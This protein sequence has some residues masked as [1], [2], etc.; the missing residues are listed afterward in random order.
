MKPLF[1]N[2]RSTSQSSR[3]NTIKLRRHTDLRAASI[4]IWLI[5]GITACFA[6][7]PATKA[8]P[9]I[10]AAP[11]PVIYVVKPKFPS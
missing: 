4:R 5:V 11:N 6:A 3:F 7:A 1:Q 2:Q 10:S 9:S 8:V